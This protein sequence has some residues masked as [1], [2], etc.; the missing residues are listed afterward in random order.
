[1]AESP[2]ETHLLEPADTQPV[3][4]MLTAEHFVLLLE[5]NSL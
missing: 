5:L 2:P 3:T 1:M 4:V